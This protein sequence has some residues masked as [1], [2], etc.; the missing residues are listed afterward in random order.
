MQFLRTFSRARKR[1]LFTFAGQR[2]GAVATAREDRPLATSS[3]KKTSDSESNEGAAGQKK[4]FARKT[5]GRNCF[6]GAALSWACSTYTEAL[7]QFGPNA[8]PF[9]LPA[10]A[11]IVADNNCPCDQWLATYRKNW[12]VV[13]DCHDANSRPG[14]TLRR[15]VTASNWSARTLPVLARI[16]RSRRSEAFFA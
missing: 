4:L 16:S 5:R 6:E 12:F 2:K 14:F 1:V 9:A 15:T 10:N 7:N 3:R 13:I 11:Q 8:P